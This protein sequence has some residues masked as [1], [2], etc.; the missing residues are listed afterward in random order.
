VLPKVHFSACP[1]QAHEKVKKRV[2][3]VTKRLGGAGAVR[4]VCD[5]I[6]VAKDNYQRLLQESL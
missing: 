6:L 2:H 3:F 5:L 4:E 1:A